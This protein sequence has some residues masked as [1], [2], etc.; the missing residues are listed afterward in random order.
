MTVTHQEILDALRSVLDPEL[1]MNVVDL[2]LVYSAGVRDRDVHVTMTMTS[3]ACP[4]GELL[5]DQAKAAIWKHVRG[6][7]S[8]SVDLVWE[9]VWNPSMMSEAAR[10]SLGWK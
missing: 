8:V 1:G 9:P 4:L 3:R 6:V 5:T 7:N 2:G 10:K